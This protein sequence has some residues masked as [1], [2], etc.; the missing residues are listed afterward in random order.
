MNPLIDILILSNGPGEITTWVRPTVA[1]LRQQQ[2]L[3][4]NLRISV[5]LSPCPHAMGNEATVVQA[6]DGVDR[7]QGAEH[8]WP[9]LLS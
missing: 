3:G 8:F 2:P 5:M 4:L 6:Y 7:V 1:A 9:F